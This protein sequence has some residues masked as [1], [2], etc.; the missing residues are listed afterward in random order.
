MNWKLFLLACPHDSVTVCVVL[1]DGRVCT[2]VPYICTRGRSAHCRA[3]RYIHKEPRSSTKSAS[4]CCSPT[5]S[6][7]LQ[8]PPS[9]ICHL[10]STPQAPASRRRPSRTSWKSKRVTSPSTT[11]L[12]LAPRCVPVFGRKTSRHARN[13]WQSFL[14]FVKK[15]RMQ[16]MFVKISLI[17]SSRLTLTQMPITSPLLLRTTRT[18][19]VCS[20]TKT[21]FL[22][23]H[24]LVKR[25]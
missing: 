5:V 10:S 7:P 25:K 12:V 16:R 9:T 23:A 22:P 21:K 11:C 4:V 19:R 3:R 1:T 13:C 20:S 2:C 14:C 17:G 6:L 15:T 18:K 24:G 8:Q